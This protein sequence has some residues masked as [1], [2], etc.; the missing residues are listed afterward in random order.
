[1]SLKIDLLSRC[2]RTVHRVFLTAAAAAGALVLLAALGI[3]HACREVKACSRYVCSEPADLPEREY[4]LL[5][6]A[7]RFVRGRFLNEF[8]RLRIDAAVRL[9]QA[10]K[11]RKI[12]VSGDN[13]RPVYNEPDDMKADLMKA[14]IP[15]DVILSD[16]AGFRTLDSVMRARSLFGTEQFTVISQRFHCER[17][18]YLARAKRLDAVGFAAEDPPLR[19]Q[20]KNMLREPLACFKAWLDIHLLGTRPKFE[21]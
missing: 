10:G 20:Y 16:Y 3:F 7:S 9:Y 5:L 11:I 12:I 14:G 17:A 4:G 8:Y 19:F 6:G 2:P 13:G 15:E 1:M 21:E 18:I